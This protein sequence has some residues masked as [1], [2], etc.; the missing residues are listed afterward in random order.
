MEQ[1]EELEAEMMMMMN[2]LRVDPLFLLL[3]GL[4]F[5]SKKKATDADGEAL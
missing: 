5:Q 4:L 1:G 3:L 2:V